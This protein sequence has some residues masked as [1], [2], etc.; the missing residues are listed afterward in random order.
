VALTKMMSADCLVDSAHRQNSHPVFGSHCKSHKACVR[1]TRKL[2]HW[3]SGRDDHAH[4][5]I[6]ADRIQLNFAWWNIR[7]RKQRT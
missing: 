4:L 1:D 3:S 6:T 7:N 2:R 5:Q